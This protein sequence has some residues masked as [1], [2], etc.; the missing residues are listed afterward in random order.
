[1]SIEVQSRRDYMRNEGFVL[2]DDVFHQ[3]FDDASHAVAVKQR[4]GEVLQE[5][6]SPSAGGLAVV[7]EHL[8]VGLHKLKAPDD[9][10]SGYGVTKKDLSRD[11]NRFSFISGFRNV[12]FTWHF[13][14]AVAN[15]VVQTFVADGYIAAEQYDNFTLGDWADIIGSAWFSD[16]MHDM[17]LT[18]NGEHRGFGEQR[19]HY[20]N[21]NNA[22]RAYLDYNPEAGSPDDNTALF[23][24]CSVYEEESGQTYLTASVT[25]NFRSY[26]REKMHAKDSPGCPVA[27]KAGTLSL[28]LVNHD[29]HARDLIARGDL[30]ITDTNQERGTVRFTQDYTPIDRALD[31]FVG[32]LDEY[33][34]QYGTPYWHTES[35]QIV[36]EYRPKT[37]ALIHQGFLPF[38]QP[39]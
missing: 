35:S 12:D 16:L 4:G 37:G 33:A 19:A 14:P 13:A 10:S 39:H 36:H 22:L 20:A 15:A 17:A 34:T 18:S 3:F 38:D 8:R 7:A 27:R 29:H 2:V 23:D 25:N 9:P 28:A 26:L 30:R 24:V 5:D 11:K 21:G 32:L 6:V 1:M 31:V